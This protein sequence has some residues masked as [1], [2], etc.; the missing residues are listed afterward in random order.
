MR[1]RLYRLSLLVTLGFAAALAMLTVWQVVRA[2]HLAFDPRNPRGVLAEERILR[3]GIYDRALRP[4][5]ESRLVRGRQVRRYPLGE[6]AAPVTGYRS[7][8]LGKTGLEAARDGDLLGR[9]TRGFL[10][11][12]R[13]RFLG[14]RPRGWDLVLT[15]DATL[16]RAAYDALAGR[17]GA[18]VVIEPRTGAVL[19]LA[20]R[21]S[22]DPNAVED[23]WSQFAADPAAPLVNRATAGQYPPGSS[24][25]VV[26]MAAA[27]SSGAVTPR[28]TFRCPGFIV[29]RGKR[30][31]DLEGRAHGIVDVMQA[32]V[33]SCNVAFIQIG[34]RAGGDALFETARALGIGTA[35]WFD[36]TSATGHL[37]SRAE[38]AG[39][40][41][42]QAA[43]G[44]GSLAV[45]PLQMALVAAAFA[46]G[47][48][49]PRPYLV[50]QVRT[51]QGRILQQAEP[52]RR[53]VLPPA[54]ARTV[55]GG[56]VEVV[57]RGTGRAAAIRG[58]EVAGKTGTA[59]NP[60][61]APHAWFIGFAPA[62]AP[63]VAIAVVV[64]HG[65]IGGE[66][67]APIARRV[68]EAALARRNGAG[69]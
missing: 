37:P 22:V 66:I 34:L 59:E 45:T 56:M 65:G 31:T 38:M 28:T 20:S 26:T 60:A 33:R 16:E 54:V 10:D 32:L 30:I 63:R 43:F 29:I 17:R 49:L 57:R 64:E 62:R 40:G 27:L 55:A 7:A 9:E 39:D 50:A 35:P 42:A 23:R 44:Q 5:A 18:V 14:R 52:D 68:L 67:A 53:R 15:I 13:N 24:F 3:G 6:A 19:A 12:V 4:L 69:R 21:P 58:V 41:V 46:N 47:G 11:E 1:R 25:K 48:E 8:Q 36:L 2:P 61:G 51:Y